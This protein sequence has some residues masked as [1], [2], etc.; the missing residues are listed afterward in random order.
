MKSEESSGQAPGAKWNRSENFFNRELSLLEFN[1]RVLELAKDRRIP[2]LERLR[3]LTI[4][5][6]NLDEFFEVRVFGLKQRIAFDVGL[7]NP[8]GLSRREVFERSEEKAHALVREQYRVLQSDILP[9]LEKEGIRILNQSSWTSEQSQWVGE[10]FEKEVLPV[11]T[12]VG[13][14]PAH[15]FPRVSNKS[16][17]FVVS[18]KGKD[19]FGRSSRAAVVQAPRLLP[20]LIPIPKAIAT[21]RHEFV[22]LSSVIHANVEELFPGMKVTG[23]YQFRVTRNSDL[24]IDE[25]E[26][27]DL[28]LAL[29]DELPGR[30]F[31]GAARLE[32]D[33]ESS[34]EMTQFLLEKSGLTEADLYRVSGPVNLHRLSALCSLDRPDLKYRPVFPASLPPALIE[35]SILDHLRTDDILLHHPY[36]SFA[37]VVRLL[38]EAATDPSVLAIKQTVYRTDADSAMVEA[39]V[40]AARAGKEVTAVVELRARFDEAANIELATRLQEAGAKVVYGIVSYKTHCKMLLVVRREGTTLRRY[41]HLGTGNYHSGT[42]RTYTDFGFMTSNEDFCSDVHDVFQQLT[43]LCKVH[44]LRKLLQAPFTLHKT[45]LRHVEKEIEAARA[46]E[47]AEIIAKMNSLVEPE[48]IKA[49]YRASKAGVKIDLIVRGIC[50]LR[51]GVPGV[52][53]NIHVRSILGRFLEHHRVFFFHDGGKRTLYLGSADWM[54]RNFFS[55]VEVCFPIEGKKFRK[56]LLEEGLMVY[57]KDNQNAWELQEDGTYKRALPGDDPPFSAQ[58]SLLEK[59]AEPSAPGL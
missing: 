13:L 4:S 10:Y 30:R 8:D 47:K 46:G 27:E 17:N 26:V 51:P 54:P 36:E 16:L 48:L 31:G 35:G 21:Q 29:K 9:A 38:Q 18:L 19:A 40:D 32:V 11:L 15:P 20:R 57:L 42:A 25:E 7:P 53:E 56:R 43:G 3:F 1:A 59:L 22:L 23:C 12:P 49:L 41:V 28:L 6:S 50:C 5:S 44:G 2:L 37:P 58:E 24:W 39:L 52:S 45:L 34:K 33:D 14:D 55:R